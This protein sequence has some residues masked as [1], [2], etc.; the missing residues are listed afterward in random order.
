[1]SYCTYIPQ[2]LIDTGGYTALATQVYRL[3]ECSDMV[4]GQ[5]RVTHTLPSLSPHTSHRV[6]HSYTVKKRFA[7]FPSPAGMSLTKLS[8]VSV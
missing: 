3:I 2:A 6:V 4:S 8:L 7:D 5:G 1:M